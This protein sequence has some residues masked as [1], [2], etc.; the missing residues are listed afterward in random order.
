MH[1]RIPPPI[2]G[3]IAL[4]L[5]WAAARYLPG[6]VYTHQIIT[7]LAAGLAALGL[8]LDLVSLGGFRRSD[9]TINPLRPERASALVTSG[10]YRISRNPMY[11][12]MLLILLGWTLYQ[13]H[14]AGLLPLA[15]F[16]AYI[17]VFQ[18]K[19]EER[20]MISLFGQDYKDYMTKVRR[21]L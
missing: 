20:A 18:I 19:P 16:I 10:P 12:G 2:I 8:A 17:T 3:I 21:W 1:N 4:A 15:G 13:G 9:T 14:P 7:I 11:L 5:I 6:P